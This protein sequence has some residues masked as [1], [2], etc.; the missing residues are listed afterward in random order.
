M[1]PGSSRSGIAA[2]PTTGE[3]AREIAMGRNQR[4][5]L[6]PRARAP[7]GTVASELSYRARSLRCTIATVV[8]AGFAA[9]HID[10]F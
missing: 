5:T 8:T 6:H 7:A 1:P 9:G 10:P 2:S 3:K 4:D